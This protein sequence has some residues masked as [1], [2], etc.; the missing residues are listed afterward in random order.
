MT[1]V[2]DSKLGGAKTKREGDKRT[3]KTASPPLKWRIR[4]KDLVL[5]LN[6]FPPKGGEKYLDDY[7]KLILKRC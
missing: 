7:I 1:S 6:L 2:W 3:W 4:G 5:K